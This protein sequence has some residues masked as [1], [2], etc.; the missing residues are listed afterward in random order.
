[1]IRTA[2]LDDTDTECSD[3]ASASALEGGQAVAESDDALDLD[4]DSEDEYEPRTDV[5]T[6]INANYVPG[7]EGEPQA[8]VA[9]MGPLN[10]TI[11]AFWRMVWLLD[12]PAIV[13]TTPLVRSVHKLVQVV[14]RVVV[15]RG[16]LWWEGLK[17]CTQKQGC[18]GSSAV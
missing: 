16:G 10:N 12:S 14:R 8:Y 3:R 17:R 7:P 11:E 9:A 4:D 2:L 18:K 6:Y 15:V 1:M 13:M 5:S